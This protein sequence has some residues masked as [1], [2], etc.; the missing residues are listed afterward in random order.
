[1]HGIATAAGASL[2]YGATVVKVTPG[3][4]KPSVTLSTGEVLTADVVVA[5]DGPRSFVRQTVFDYEDDAKPSGTTVFGG[6]IPAS[7][8]MHDPELAKMVKSPEA[9]QHQRILCIFCLTATRTVANVHGKQLQHLSCVSFLSWKRLTGMF[10]FFVQQFIRWCAST[11]YQDHSFS[12]TDYVILAGAFGVRRTASLARRGSQH[13]GSH[14]R[15]M[16]RDCTHVHD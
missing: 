15:L 16:V 4:P 11:A 3:H 6:V 5:A 14:R 8:M 1:M 9:S 13:P 12:A 2:R 7:K 10:M